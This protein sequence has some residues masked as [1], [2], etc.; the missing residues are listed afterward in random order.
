MI[1]QTNNK[2]IKQGPVGAPKIMG[3]GMLMQHLW[4]TCNH[5]QDPGLNLPTWQKIFKKL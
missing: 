1:K 2:K 3:G 4:S 5:E